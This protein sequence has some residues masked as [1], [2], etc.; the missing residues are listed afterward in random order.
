MSAKKVTTEEFIC[1]ASSVHGGKYRYSDIKYNTLHDKVLI[2]CPTHGDFLQAANDHLRGRGCKKC[3][4][5]KMSDCDRFVSKSKKVHGDRYDYSSVEYIKSNEKVDII[6]KIHGKFSQIPSTHLQGAGCC[7]CGHAATRESKIKTIDNFVEKSKKIHGDKF[8]YDKVI[9]KGRDVKVIISCPVHGEFEQSPR[10]HFRNGCKY[11]GSERQADSKRITNS[12]FIGKAMNRHGNKYS[13]EKCNYS[14]GK[15]RVIIG[16]QKHGD[17]AQIAN[18]HL[19]GAGCPSCVFRRMTKEEFVSESIKVHG[20]F[21]DYTSANYE[22][23][24]VHVD[25]LCPNHGAFSQTPYQH[26]LGNGC[27]KCKK[28]NGETKIQIILEE[29]GLW[30][31]N[32]AKFSTCRYKSHLRFDFLINMDS[33]NVDLLSNSQIIESPPRSI[34]LIE[35]HGTHHYGPVVRSYRSS[36]EEI[37]EVY[38]SIQTKDKIKEQWC[39]D[40]SIP[41]LV[42]PY[43][44]YSNIKNIIETF[45]K[46][47]SIPC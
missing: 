14:G 2:F 4:L 43:W 44:E 35:F 34:F 3:F 26:I 37:N 19:N 41:L 23:N 6:C 30:Y 12:A 11:C 18:T 22:R 20:H 32:E 7:K 31:R 36:I 29:M 17:F 8:N 39:R 40:N 15:N 27:P 9:Y 38:E 13:Y 42:I 33:K 16:C 47:I 10:N 24:F 45:V 21:Y 25:I 5:E 1:R 46:S 28:S